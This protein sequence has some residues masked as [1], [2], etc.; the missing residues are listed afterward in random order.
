MFLYVCACVCVYS[1]INITCQKETNVCVSKRLPGVRGGGFSSTTTSEAFIVELKAI[2][3]PQILL[4]KLSAPNRGT[5]RGF[6]TGSGSDGK[7]K[8]S[9]I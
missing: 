3:E 6:K 4:I 2:P 8:S 5:E 7:G 9:Q 1:H